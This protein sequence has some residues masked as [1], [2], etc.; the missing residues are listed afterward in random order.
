M[1]YGLLVFVLFPMLAGI[2]GYA[3]GRKSEKNRNDW[4]DVSMFVQLILLICMLVEYKKGWDLKLGI[5]AVFGM[6]FSLEM[7]PVRILLCTMIFIVYFVISQY[8]KAS[9]KKEKDLNGFYFLFMV[10]QGL[11]Y[12][13]VLSDTIFGYCLF[14][15]PAYVLLLPMLLQRQNE[16]I[17]KHA[18]TYSLMTG[19]SFGL[20]MVA[21]LLLFSQYQHTNFNYLFLYGRQQNTVLVLIAGI[22]LIIG[23]G[24]WAGMFPL[25]QLVTKSCSTGLMEVSTLGGLVLSKLGAFGMVLVA[26]SIFYENRL[27]GKIILVWSLCAIVFGLCYSLLSTDIRK[28][29]LGINITS[30]GMI[31]LAGSIALFDV[32]SSVYPMRSVIWLLLASSVGL[33]VL[34]MISLEFVRKARTYEIKGL[35]QV[36]KGNIVM[37]VAAFLAGASLIGVPGTFG[38]LGQSLLLKSILTIVQWKWLLGV[39]VIQWAFYMTAIARLYMKLFISKKDETMHIMVSEEELEASQPKKEPSDPQNA[40]WFGQ[41]ILVVLSF[42]LVVIGILPGFTIDFMAESVEKYFQLPAYDGGL[43]YFTM[44]GIISFVITAI[45]AFI[46]YL[47]LVHGI[48][49]RAIKNKKNKK[50]QQEIEKE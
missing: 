42:L 21:L 22:V 20:I 45:L 29:L 39:Y 46:L 9:L 38:F 37:A 28:I 3:L 23:F 47:N 14:M 50:L 35:I 34:Y 30:N 43:K 10:S 2:I 8:M 41:M 49:L 15:V 25:Q 13:T 18:K 6:G 19:V 5:N 31:V 48:V 32:K 26:R 7:E 27:M 11:C 36:G 16:V 44:D 40:Y 17:R 1:N 12:G 24:I 4:I 33:L